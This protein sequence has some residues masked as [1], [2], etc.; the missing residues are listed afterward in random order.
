[1]SLFNFATPKL[2]FFNFVNFEQW[3][4][5]LRIEGNVTNVGVHYLS[6]TKIVD[7]E[8]QKGDKVYLW[9]VTSFLSVYGATTLEELN[10]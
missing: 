10:F 3:K 8:N 7:N 4:E 1:M 5:I 6:Q 2:N 9:S